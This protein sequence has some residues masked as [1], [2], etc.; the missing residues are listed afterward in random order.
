MLF[1]GPFETVFVVVLFKCL[2]Q[3]IYYNS[4]V[5]HLH[6][7]NIKLC[8]IILTR[9]TNIFAIEIHNKHRNEI[10]NVVK[11]ED[12]VLGELRVFNGN[13]GAVAFGDGDEGG[14]LRGL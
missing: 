9:L 1:E 3:I 7:F 2:R 4:K 14:V 5:F 11:F 13:G 6:P 12:I 8:S 10:N